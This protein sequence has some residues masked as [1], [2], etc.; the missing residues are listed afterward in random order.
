MDSTLCR[1]Q[2]TCQSFMRVRRLA[3][4]LQN[5]PIRPF[6]VA[7]GT[8]TS[9]AQFAGDARSGSKT[10]FNSPLSIKGE[11]FAKVSRKPAARGTERPSR[12]AG[13]TGTGQQNALVPLQTLSYAH[14]PYGVQHACYDFVLIIERNIR[15]RYRI[16][17]RDTQS[18]RI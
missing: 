18:Q 10:P 1:A 7:K 11:A 15:S 2:S 17:A 13:Q 6:R 14:I 16:D 4:P 12:G 8:R 3:R 5:L 9:V